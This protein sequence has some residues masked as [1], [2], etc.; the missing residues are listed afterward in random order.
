MKQINFNPDKPTPEDIEAFYE[1]CRSSIDTF[2]DPSKNHNFANDFPG[3]T[4]EERDDV[5]TGLLEELSLRS[6]FYLLAYIESLFRSDFALRVETNGKKKYQDV[7]TRAYKV[8]F[9]P[10]RKIYS[11]PLGDVIFD[12]WKRY[13]V[14]KPNSKEMQDVL[15]NLPQ[16]FEFRNWMA[17]GRYWIFK[18]NNNARKYNYTQTR[19]LLAHIE[20]YFGPFLKSKNFGIQP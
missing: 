2:F 17:L 19:I 5:K 3:L 18:E 13:A 6:S 12:N 20:Q 16:Y 9:N 14:N 4:D 11:Y 7:L 10:A 15:R 1:Q 8:E